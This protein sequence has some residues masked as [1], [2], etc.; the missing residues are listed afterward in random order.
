MYLLHIC[1]FA[2]TYISLHILYRWSFIRKHIL[3]TSCEYLLYEALE[4]TTTKQVQ[5]PAEGHSWK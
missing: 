2:Y 4:V 5:S 3:I 1:V